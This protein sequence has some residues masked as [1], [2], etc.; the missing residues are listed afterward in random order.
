VSGTSGVNGSSGLTGSNGTSGTSGING[1][2]GSQGTSGTS[3][4]N[5]TS[6][7]NGTNGLAGTSGLNGSNGTSGTSGISPIFNSGSYAT[8]GSNQFLGNQSISGSLTITEAIIGDG[9]IKLQ[10]DANDVRYLEIYNTAAQDTH[11][12]ASAG[13]LFL[14]DD[15]TY[16]NVRNSGNEDTI[17][18]KADKG[19]L[20]SGST[21][22]TGSVSIT[23]ILHLDPINPLPTT[24]S[25]T[26][27]I[28][29][30]GSG[31]Y[32][33]NATTAQWCEFQIVCPTTST[34]TT[35]SGTTTTTAQT[36]Y[37][38]NSNIYD[39]CPCTASAGFPVVRSSTPLTSGG[40]TYY[41]KASIV[42]LITTPAT[43]PSYAVDLDGYTNSNTICETAKGC[44]TTTTTTAAPTTTT[45][46][47]GTT[48]TT[49]GTT[50]TTAGTTTT[51]TAGTTTTTTAAPTTSTTTTTADPNVNSYRVINC[52]NAT[53]F[54]VSYSGSLATLFTYKFLGEGLY[55]GVTCWTVSGSIGY[56]SGYSYV[57]NPSAIAYFG[58][59]SCNGTT[60]STTTTTAAPTSTTTTT[61]GTTTS[62]TTT[63]E[64]PTTT[65]TTTEYFTTTTTAGTTTTTA[66]TTTTTTDGTTTTTAGTTTTTTDGTTTTTAA[67]T[68]TTTTTE[69]TTTTTTNP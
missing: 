24:G 34:T 47:S 64:A 57:T 6:G 51:T 23:K 4:L 68:S 33:Y 46:T 9:N 15:E 11:I 52:D 5:G 21:Q 53:Q 65:S 69:G 27:D 62:T 45:T 59:E 2:D 63:T 39:N 31:V 38:Y 8:T 50:T 20:I 41:N 56:N 49:A 67:P 60:T 3:G 10:P 25:R 29:V 55:N 17:Y 66:G 28:A 12:T 58:C 1:A 37:Y 43:G 16:V 48:T 42:Y 35:T 54:D 40:T 7:I 36:F 13:Y 18:V 26:G 22:I 61:D 19:L 44:S 32:F 14:G 30:S